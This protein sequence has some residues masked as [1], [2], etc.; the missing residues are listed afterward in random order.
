MHDPAG[1]MKS[2]RGR[3]GGVLVR[4]HEPSTDTQ[5]AGQPCGRTET[6]SVSR[7]IDAFYMI[8]GASTPVPRAASIVLSSATPA[9]KQEMSLCPST[10]VHSIGSIGSSGNLGRPMRPALSGFL[11]TP[12]PR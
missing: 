1:Y 6:V 8:S 9:L 2:R 10:L 4:Q 11:R 3:T 12:P 5:E 7:G